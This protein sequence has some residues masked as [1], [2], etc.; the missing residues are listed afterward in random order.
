MGIEIVESHQ[1]NVNF[2][3]RKLFTSP[4]EI[5]EKFDLNENYY[6][7]MVENGLEMAFEVHGMCK[8]KTL[9]LH[10]ISVHL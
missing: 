9:H 7:T 5:F 2:S 4:L 1:E 10:H 6:I 3:E 8:W